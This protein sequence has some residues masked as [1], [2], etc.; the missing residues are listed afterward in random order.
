[1][2][3]GGVRLLSAPGVVATEVS[4]EADARAAEV[5]LGEAGEL[6]LRGVKPGRAVL[7]LRGADGER[8]FEVEVRPATPAP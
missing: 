7:R 1:V 3:A 8:T 2:S 4:G 6:V 5:E